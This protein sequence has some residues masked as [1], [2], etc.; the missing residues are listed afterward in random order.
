M[1]IR[2]LQYFLTIV[3][4]E[5]ISHAAEI[6]HITQP[7]LSRQIAQLEDSL[8]VTLFHRGARKITLTDEGML[9]RRR[10]EEILALVDKTE[11]ELSAQDM[12]ID[13]RI[14]IGCGE[15]A[16]VQTLPK[17]IKAFQSAYPLVRFDLIT[18]NAD[19][20]KEQIEKGLVDIGVLLEPIDKTKFDFIRLSVPE[21]WVI[22]MRPDDPLAEKNAISPADLSGKSIIL[23]KRANLQSELAS[24]FG[25][26]FQHIDVRFTSNFTT[27]SAIMVDAGLG[28][29]LVIEGSLP[30][31]DKQ[32][33]VY[34]PLS[35]ALTASSVIAWKKEQPQNLATSKFINQLSCS[36]SIDKYEI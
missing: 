3:R 30:F 19:V 2:V 17:A 16:A 9:L 6:L 14:V 1:E 23:P 31:W 29:S 18:A 20:I 27:N 35:P 15:L 34:R 26:T 25:E 33:I 24:W 36:L 10:A 11:Q 8:G 4:E 32:H 5:N 7:T 22:V 21:S 13:G 28:Y 12:L